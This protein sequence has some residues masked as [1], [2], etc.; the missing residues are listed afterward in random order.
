MLVLWLWHGLL[1]WTRLGCRFVLVI[2][3][4]FFNLR[5]RW[6]RGKQREGEFEDVGG[7]GWSSVYEG[8]TLDFHSRVTRLQLP[9]VSCAMLSRVLCALP[10][11]PC[12]LKPSRESGR[13]LQAVPV[14]AGVHVV[15]R[16]A[17]PLFNGRFP[18]ELGW[19]ASFSS[20]DC[21]RRELLGINATVVLRP[22]S[23]IYKCDCL[24]WWQSTCIGFACS[25]ITFHM[26]RSRGKMSWS[27]P[28]MCLSVP[29]RI[30]TLLHGPGCN[31]GNGR[32]AL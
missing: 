2:S 32:G 5:R 30:P 16:P 26:R 15:L 17:P 29:R 28:S 19:P 11:H 21:S 10:S 3:G 24:R 22:F 13:V 23:E 27:R 31:S 7:T 9:L 12:P 1:G 20:S 18:C 25:L 14:G 4:Q 8:S 6:G